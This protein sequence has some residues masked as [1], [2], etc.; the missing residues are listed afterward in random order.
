MRRLFVFDWDGTLMDSVG[1][2]VSCLRR[3]AEEQGLE[4][5]GDARF[6]DVIGLGLPQAIAQLYPQLNSRQVERF[7]A[8]YAA[9]FVAADAQPSQLFPGAL[10][11][12]EALSARGHWIAVAT[13][14]SRRGLDR[15]LGE[16]GLDDFFHATR[17]ADE[18][19]SKPDPRMLHE[20]VAQLGAGPKHTVMI[21]DSEYDLEMAA[22]ARIPSLG[23]SYGVHSRERLARHAP[24]R[25]VDSLPEILE[26]AELR[27]H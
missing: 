25:I 4:D 11:L 17:C 3:A 27:P 19:A 26:W 2:I 9:R 7:R 14:K 23:V 5:L 15:V 6:G 12:L 21:G 18:T 20:I 16:I 24:A 22:R 8:A 13:G 10:Q 1:R